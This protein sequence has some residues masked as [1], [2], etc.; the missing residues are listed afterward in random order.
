MKIKSTVDLEMRKQKCNNNLY[1]CALNVAWGC[2]IHPGKLLNFGAKK[3]EGPFKS[4][5]F[6]QGTMLNP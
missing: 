6:V 5:D 1:T 3:V 4:K 2:K